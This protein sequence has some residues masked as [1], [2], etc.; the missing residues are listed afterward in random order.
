[1][2]GSKRAVGIGLFG[3]IGA[4]WNGLLGGMGSGE[5][6]P[7]CSVRVEVRIRSEFRPVRLDVL[8][9]G[10]GR[11]C[12]YYCRSFGPIIYVLSV[13][14]T[15]GNGPMGEVP[16]PRHTDTPKPHDGA[17]HFFFEFVGALTAGPASRGAEKW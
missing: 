13:L 6:G 5:A 10:F 2:E 4:D 3:W 15:A 17:G 12:R 9:S 11:Y 14:P 8:A 16:T 1:M 7:Q